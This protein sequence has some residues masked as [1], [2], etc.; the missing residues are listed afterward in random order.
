MTHLAVS[1]AGWTAI[2]TLA[3]AVAT[4]VAIIV[5]L[6]LAVTDRR[7]DDD[8]RADDRA[9]NDEGVLKTGNRDDPPAT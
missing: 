7:R 8:R 3:L 1:D 2:G 9:R 5:T 4:V 6:A